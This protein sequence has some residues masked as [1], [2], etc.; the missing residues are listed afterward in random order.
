MERP[1]VAGTEDDRTPKQLIREKAERDLL[2]QV[3][4]IQR[5]GRR[6]GCE[7]IKRQPASEMS[8]KNE[9]RY[10]LITQIAN[11]GLWEWNLAT[12]E[13][14]FSHRWKSMLGY[15]ENEIGND[16]EE[17]F[18]RIHPEDV[19]R[20]KDGV[21]SYLKGNS[22][23]FEDEY[24]ML[25]RDGTYRWMLNR[26]GI[27]ENAYGEPC[28]IVGIQTDMTPQKQLYDPLT[29]LPNRKLFMSH[30]ERAIARAGRQKK[31]L[32]A[33][34][35]LDLDRF[36]NINE[37]LGHILGD[38][39]LIVLSQRLASGLRAND[40][41]AHLGGDEFAILLD[42]IRDT[43]DATRVA[44]RIQEE[45]VLPFDLDGQVVF[46]SVSIGIVLNQP[47]YKLPEE[48]LRDAHTAMY[49]AKA[50]GKAR[51]EMFDTEMHR[52]AVKR[53]QL[54][55]DLRQAA[56]NKDF[57]IL[58]QPIVSLSSHRI[59]CVEA[60]LR[61][62]HPQR[63]LILP[64]GFIE[65][66]EETGLIVPIGEWVLRTAC[67]QTKA[68]QDAGYPGL[69]LA[70]NISARQFQQAGLPQVIR[71]VL[72]ETGLVAEHLGLEI[73]EST[74][75]QDIEQSVKVLDELASMGLT[76][77]I[78]DFG[79][80][81]SSFEYLKRF[82]LHTLKIDR[83]FIKDIPGDS[84]DVAITTAIIAMAHS[85]NLNVIA[86]GIETEEQLGY[87]RSQQCDEGQ[88]YLFSW[89]LSV[90]MFTDLSWESL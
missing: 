48:L 34:L 40:V 65:I 7:I 42:D 52:R 37:S 39:L 59:T 49:R 84:N 32:F 76:I 45:L 28:L 35:F 29:S 73:T 46:T 78:D 33:V 22:T 62:K 31:Y 82:P 17:W 15:K 86:E 58:Y 71:R 69:R 43:S 12:N 38:R 27:I 80:G 36:K 21:N 3:I 18:Q 66:A 77:S 81:Y 16:P 56:E 61:W 64:A 75:M 90:E 2:K 68:W 47:G 57:R 60:L 1:I 83:S 67:A 55:S 24:R 53:L 5:V 51:H 85:L 14:F 74:A 79:T 63:G 30:V 10:A 88:G 44:D 70:V 6:L 25:H 26:A 89:P 13:A 23:R 87:L 9:D 54:E 4:H 19:S 72:D 8:G 50:L 41:V 20:V 11:D